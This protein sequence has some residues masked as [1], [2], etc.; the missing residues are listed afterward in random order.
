M[1][2]KSNVV[3]T[4]SSEQGSH[5]WAVAPESPQLGNHPPFLLTVSLLTPYYSPYFRIL[6]EKKRWFLWKQEWVSISQM[7]QVDITWGKQL[8]L[9]TLELKQVG[10]NFTARC[11]TACSGSQPLLE[12]K[13]GRPHKIP[14]WHTDY[15][16]LRLLDMQ[17]APEGHLDLEFRK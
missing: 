6:T 11:Q 16:A 7:K 13:T 9:R 8:P 5:R 1:S 2:I 12:P 15:I 10:P 14:Q 17:P 4:L 3:R